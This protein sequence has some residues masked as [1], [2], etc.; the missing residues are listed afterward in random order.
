MSKTVNAALA[1]ASAVFS[2]VSPRFCQSLALLSAIAA[3]LLAAM[4]IHP[5]LYLLTLPLVMLFFVK[6]EK[7][8]PKTPTR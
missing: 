8:E 1:K 7:R 3:V 4:A 6:H 5:I 2:H